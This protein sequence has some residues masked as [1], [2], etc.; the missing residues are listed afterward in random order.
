MGYSQDEMAMVT[1]SYI[2]MIKNRDQ[3]RKIGAKSKL[4]D[5]I[6][7]LDTVPD[8]FREPKKQSCQNSRV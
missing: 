5:S 2:A 7:N 1:L 8:A 3:K 6:A 4:D